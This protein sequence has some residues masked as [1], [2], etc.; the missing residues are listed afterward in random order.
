MLITT[1]D[2]LHSCVGKQNVWGF[3]LS[4]FVLIQKNA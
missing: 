1:W 4:V 2:L 3:N